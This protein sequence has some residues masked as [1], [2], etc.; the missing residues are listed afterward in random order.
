MS[1]NLDGTTGITTPAIDLTT[2][3]P[4]VD[5]GTGLTS[6][7][8]SGN[9]LTS[10]GTNWASTT[11]TNICRAWVTF[12]GGASSATIL[13]SYNVTS[14][15]RTGTGLYTITFTNALPDANYVMTGTGI[16][17]SSTTNTTIGRPLGGTISASSVQIS[18][19]VNNT[20]FALTD[21]PWV[22][23]AFFR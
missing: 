11:P 3:L 16:A 5:G 17:T 9:V 4:I 8:T 23:L 6:A 22:S 2:P 15:T 19:G 21:L 7:G 20:S 12:A 10:D 13:A 14:V 1:I 18:I